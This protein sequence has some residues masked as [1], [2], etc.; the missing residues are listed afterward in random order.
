MDNILVNATPASAVVGVAYDTDGTPFI[1]PGSTAT[2]LGLR[3]KLITL[4]G[5]TSGVLVTGKIG[6]NV[7]APV[8]TPQ[9]VAEP[10]AQDVVDALVT[11]GLITQ[12]ASA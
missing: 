5:G 2:G 8:S 9:V 7:A 3:G 12:E 6:F 1:T 10:D 4:V 11:L